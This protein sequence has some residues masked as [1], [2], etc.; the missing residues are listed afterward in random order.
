[1]LNVKLLVGSFA[2]AAGVWKVWNSTGPW[3]LV[4]HVLCALVVSW[5]IF[6]TVLYL[7]AAHLRR[8]PLRSQLSRPL[9]P[10]SRATRDYATRFKRDR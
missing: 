10:A 6:V 3:S 5:V 9:S 8:T 1:M 2:L 7:T 4:L